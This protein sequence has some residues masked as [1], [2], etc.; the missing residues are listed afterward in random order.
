MVLLVRGFGIEKEDFCF[1]FFYRAVGYFELRKNGI[2]LR[3][4]VKD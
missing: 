2:M 1:E 4:V 3:E